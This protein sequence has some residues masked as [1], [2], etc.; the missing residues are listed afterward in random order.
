M[1]SSH[2]GARRLSIP[3]RS[4]LDRRENGSSLQQGTFTLLLCVTA[5]SACGGGQPTAASESSGDMPLTSSRYPSKVSTSSHSV[6][7]AP[8][9][10]LSGK[11]FGP[12][13]WTDVPLGYTSSFLESATQATNANIWFADVNAN[14][15]GEISPTG[16]VNLYG[17][18]QFVGVNPGSETAAEPRDI[19]AG[20][21]S[22]TYF[23][24]QFQGYGVVSAS[25]TPT[26]YTTAYV[27]GLSYLQGTV[28]TMAV[29]PDGSAWFGA[30]GGA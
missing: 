5:L 16:V 20:P 8:D 23:L 30:Y 19:E 13:P 17:A 7:P 10:T 9:A 2:S 12:Q 14:L 4:R 25:G 27:D 28:N 18:G 3:T 15:I 24:G 1:Q 22:T 6:A 26:L 21:N 29:S 11:I